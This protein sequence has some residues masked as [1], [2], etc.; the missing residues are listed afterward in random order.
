[1][2]TLF[3]AAALLLNLVVAA[4]SNTFMYEPNPHFGGDDPDINPS[5]P[6]PTF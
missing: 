1:M 4:C 3:A 5:A 6:S 2:K